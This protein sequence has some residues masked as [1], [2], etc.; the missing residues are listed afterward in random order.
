MHRVWVVT[1]QA[2]VIV[3]QQ[4]PCTGGCT[5]RFGS[6]VPL[7]NQIAGVVQLA[8]VVTAQVPSG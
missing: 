8:A 4:A 5:Q 1:V 7:S 2:P 6:H 3:L